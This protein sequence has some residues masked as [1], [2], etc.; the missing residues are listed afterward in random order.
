MVCS[1]V[2][3]SHLMLSFLGGFCFLSE[4]LSKSYRNPVRVSSLVQTVSFL[5]LLG[6]ATQLLKKTSQ[7]KHFL[8]KQERTC[9]LHS[10]YI[11]IFEKK[12]KRI[13]IFQNNKRKDKWKKTAL[14]FHAYVL[15]TNWKTRF[16]FPALPPWSVFLPA[17]PHGS[18]PYNQQNQHSKN[19]TCDLTTF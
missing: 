5:V 4:L 13:N 12:K 16:L 18:A 17:N 3:F 6:E 19:P 10:N 2:S 8:L 7:R 14:L 9:L 15:F 1:L 11:W